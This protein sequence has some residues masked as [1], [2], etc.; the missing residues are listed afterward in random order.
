MLAISPT[1]HNY[2]DILLRGGIQ[3][4]FHKNIIDYLYKILI[5]IKLIKLEPMSLGSKPYEVIKYIEKNA[6]KLKDTKIYFDHGS[7]G[8]DTYY[9]EPQ[10]R[11]NE[12]LDAKGIKYKYEVFKGHGHDAKYFGQR[13]GDILVYLVD[14]K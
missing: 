10:K 13:Y 7:L 1:S 9:P 5:D 3:P 14:S 2:Y 12:I 6:D 11:V 4:R 8:L